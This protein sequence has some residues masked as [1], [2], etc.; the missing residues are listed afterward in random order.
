MDQR[1]LESMLLEQI[2]QL[3]YRQWAGSM[4]THQ[5]I[6][7]G[8]PPIPAEAPY[9]PQAGVGANGMSYRPLA[10]APTTGIARAEVTRLT[11][12]AQVRTE[13]EPLREQDRMLPMANVARLMTNQLPPSAKIAKDTKVLMQEMVSEFIA[14]LTSEANDISIG[15]GRRAIAPEDVIA[16][17][18]ELDL[19]SFVPAT[20]AGAAG[21]MSSRDGAVSS[22]DLEG[23]SFSFSSS[24][25]SNNRSLASSEPQQMPVLARV[26]AQPPLSD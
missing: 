7:S 13:P 3:T 8:R 26:L 16:A 15:K 1:E 17:L 9:P 10:P 5:D 6:F 19:D 11:R 12:A 21:A 18:H 24:A 4:T 25:D 14:F 2:N 20:V 23:S 22:S